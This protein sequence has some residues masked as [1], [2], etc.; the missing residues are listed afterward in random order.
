MTPTAPRGR[1]FRKYVVVLLVLVGGVL[2][3]SSLVDLYFVYRETQLAIVRVERA[4]AV[5][6]A[7]R[8]EQFLKDVELQ[9]RETTRTASDDPD[10]SQVGT[11]KLGFRQGLGA[12]LAEQRE[13]D[14]LRVLRNVAAIT[15]LTHLD[16][17]GKEQLRV[18]RLDPD[19]VGSQ[20]DL[21][22]TPRFTEARAGKVYWSPVYIKN[23]SE[24]YV[25]LAIPVGKYAVEVTAAEISLGPVL[26]IVSQIEV[27]RNGYAYVVDS[28]DQLVAHPNSRVLRERRDV[29][30]LVQV[31]AARAER[32]G[33]A[34]D[35]GTVTRNPSLTPYACR[36]ASLL[37]RLVW[38][39]SILTRA[40][41]R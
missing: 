37:R 10:A 32:K 1:L 3:A 14:F 33:A 40:P 25:T 36:P 38:K 22:R 30:G 5:A 7:G 39:R 15:Q 18:S 23:D 8:I 9:V 4:K 26:K 6:A 17:A 29:S 2:M 19:V 34:T 16:L 24:P 12:A 11:A 41:C 20:E 21:A 13:L 31:K 35:A 28:K 27:G